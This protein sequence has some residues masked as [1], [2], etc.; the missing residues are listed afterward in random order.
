MTRAAWRVNHPGY[1]RALQLSLLWLVTVGSLTLAAGGCSSDDDPGATTSGGEGGGGGT[2]LVG[3]DERD[4]PPKPDLPAVI[5]RVET[6]PVHGFGDAADD[7]VIIVHPV[8]PQDS[9]VLATDKTAS[10][11]LF[12]YDLEGKE[13]DFLALGELNNVDSRPFELD[14]KHVE[15][16]TATNRTDDTLVL[17]A[18]D[19]DTRRFT[20]VATETVETTPGS[21]GLCMYKSPSGDVFAFVNNEQ[22]RFVQYQLTADGQSVQAEQVREFCL[23]TQPEGCVADDAHQRLF[24]GEEAYGLWVF[25]AQKDAP[26][27]GEDV[28]D[29]EG[30]IAGKM[31]ASTMDPD[32]VLK[33]DVEGMAIA[34]AGAGEG[35]LVV[36]A[37]GEHE[38]VLFDR[39]PPYDHRLTLAVWGGGPACIDGVQETDGLDVSSADLGGEFSAGLLVVQDGFNGDPVGKQNFKLVS[40]GDV[41]SLIDEPEQ[42]LQHNLACNLGDYGGKARYADLPPGPERT[43]AL[44][45]AFCGRCAACYEEGD[46]GFAEGDCHYKSPKPN[47]EHDDCLAGCNAGFVPQSTQALQPGWESWPCLDLDDAL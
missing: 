15:L 14:G 17:L 20:D 13:L 11:G 16:I 21:Y 3:I 10:G 5:P 28:P 33:P 29:C 34:E 40:W 4:P 8:R 27:T 38:L 35:Y 18:Y 42:E 46:P 25:P 32:R 44:C 19:Y 2:G 45:E 7:P 1:R 24:A 22:G 26:S 41:L 12:V 30:A 31:I 47:Y 36:S 6:E 23:P 43:L 39:N 9:V 37:Q